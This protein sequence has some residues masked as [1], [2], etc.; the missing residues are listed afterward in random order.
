M[1]HTSPHPLVEL[2]VCSVWDKVWS[3]PAG[4]VDSEVAVIDGPSGRTHTRGD[5]K[6]KSQQL[7]YGYRQLGLTPGQVVCIF[8][9]NSFYYHMIVL[10]AQC[11]GCVLSGANA[12]YTPQEMAHQLS[13]SSTE[14]LMCHPSNLDVALKATKA[15]GWSEHKQKERIVLAVM[16]DEA[17]PAGNTYKSISDLVKSKHELTPFRVEDPKSTVAYLG[18]SSGTSGKA[19]GVRTSHYNMTS[20]LSILKPFFVTKD[21]VHL[22]V[23]PLNHI[24]GLTK[25][26]HWPL[27]TGSKVVVMPKFELEPFCAIVQKYKCSVCMLVP[28]IALLLA[29]EPIV[30][31]YDFSSMRLIVSGA[32]PLSGEL[33]EE[34][35]KRLGAAVC[36]AYGLTETSPTTHYCPIETPTPGS[37]GPLLPM[38]RGRIVDPETG[39]DVEPGEQGEMWVQGPNVMLGYLNR[40]EANAETLVEDAHGRWLKTGDI[41]WVDQ[42]GYYFITDRLKELIKY[43]GFQ[44]APAELEGTCLECPYVADVAVIGV[45][46]DDQASELPRAYVVLSAEGKKQ[47]DGAKAVR[48]WVDQ[49]VS[50]HKKLRGGVKIVDMVPKSPSG[51]LLRRILRE[52]AKAE[53]AQAKAAKQKAKL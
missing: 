27:I 17:G 4:L 9:P 43:K 39:K 3:N 40:P 46:D 22:A 30:D 45:W 8:S 48:E 47:T 10:A 42:K 26:L 51:K 50:A 41:A 32:A 35:S 20:V 11:A 38:M 1:I 5:L 16:A 28:P 33:A 7:A 29:R 49:R 2:P 19:K 15:V 52:E 44:V 25:L 31:S 34:V 23:L 18:Y 6:K 14:L 37:I 21:D 53:A 13:D 12:A 24:Y 36:Q